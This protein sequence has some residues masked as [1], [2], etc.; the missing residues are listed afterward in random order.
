M[1]PPCTRVQRTRN[2]SAAEGDLTGGNLT[3]GQGTA[4][5]DVTSTFSR[6]STHTL[7]VTAVLTGD[8]PPTGTVTLQSADGCTAVSSGP[9]E[10]TKGWGAQGAQF[11]ASLHV[12]F[13]DRS[14]LVNR[15]CAF[16]VTYSGNGAY[17]S[18]ESE[19]ITV[20][21]PPRNTDITLK[22]SGVHAFDAPVFLG[23]VAAYDIHVDTGDYPISGNVDL[24]RNGVT[25]A[26]GV[27][28][29]K[30]DLHIERTATV[31]GP[32]ALVATF[33]PDTDAYRSS[34]AEL[35]DEWVAAPVV[36]TVDGGT[37]VAT[38][39]SA[40]SVT[41]RYAA[42]RYPGLVGAD[43]PRE[44]PQGA[45]SITGTGGES[46]PTSPRWGHRRPWRPRARVTCPT[47]PGDSGRSPRASPR[48]TATRAGR[49]RPS[50]RS[51]RA[52]RPPL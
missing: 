52:L 28:D 45:V 24:T 35:K 44:A 19:R 6:G 42:E 27:P 43:L 5:I 47:P 18:A 14:D 4:G 3:V 23:S 40:V 20:A 41:V 25:I 29:S 31:E 16:V 32:G 1:S 34:R 15:D 7:Q 30:G 33:R 49:V 2:K 50:C 21:F 48:G 10:V 38:G 13:P 11:G 22:R 26:Q 51:G 37:P 9:V 8:V 39:Y 12:D 36:V 17:S 46:W